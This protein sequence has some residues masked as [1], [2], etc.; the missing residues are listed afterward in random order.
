MVFHTYIQYKRE[1]Y[2]SG[3]NPVEF[4]RFH[5]IFLLSLHHSLILI[6]NTC[7]NY[8]NFSVLKINTS[9]SLLP[10][11]SSTYHIPVTT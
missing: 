2:Y 3:I 1:Y 5:I 8:S 11:H 7:K 9:I 10:K 4:R 6:L